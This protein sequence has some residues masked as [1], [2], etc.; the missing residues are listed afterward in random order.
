MSEG[1]ERMEQ[2]HP[3][4]DVLTR[5]LSEHEKKSVAMNQ[6]VYTVIS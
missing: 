5:D 4:K 3:T 1:R 2:S 6:P